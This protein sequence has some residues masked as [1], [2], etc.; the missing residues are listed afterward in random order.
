M[1]LRKKQMLI[2]DDEAAD[3]RTVH[4]ALRESRA[5]DSDLSGCS[6]AEGIGVDVGGRETGFD[7]P[8]NTSGNTSGVFDEEAR[9]LGFADEM[10][11]IG[12]QEQVEE[13]SRESRRNIR[14]F[15]EK[16][17]SIREKE[18]KEIANNLH[19]EAG[20]MV[21]GLGSGLEIAEEEIKDGNLQAAL[22][23]IRQ[24]K[25]SLAKTAE[26]LRGIVTDLRPMN[27]DMIGLPSALSQYCSDIREQAKI[28]VHFRVDNISEE[29]IGDNTATVLYRVTQEALTNAIK[30]ATA[31]KVKI[32][33]YSEE[34]NIKLDLCDDGKGFDI[35][36]TLRESKGLGIRG[37]GERVRSLGGTVI[38]KSAPE[39]GTDISV[40]L[41][42]Y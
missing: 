22:K 42:K 8:I 14:E 6:A 38:I 29:T 1:R 17:L 31:T 40:T 3:P 30:H 41:P 21:V 9:I 19:D 20:S 28:E 27:L 25:R 24:A 13:E 11:D 12:Q 15:L 23:A 36:K 32:R 26:N 16:I 34:E 7:L 18:K 33:L 4:E 10:R 35:Y 37:M 2:I 5:P 39:K